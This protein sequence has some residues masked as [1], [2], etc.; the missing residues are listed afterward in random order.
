LN[1]ITFTEMQCTVAPSDSGVASTAVAATTAAAAAA[2]A[3]AA[4]AASEVTTMLGEENLACR[5][6][7]DGEGV[8]FVSG[9]EGVWMDGK[10]A[11][12]A[13]VGGMPLPVDLADA[14]DASFSVPEGREACLR[15]VTKRWTI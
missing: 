7:L 14:D 10:G 15:C 12:D 13:E 2:E 6:V 3:E 4:G 8:R 5:F 1:T 9:V 11:A